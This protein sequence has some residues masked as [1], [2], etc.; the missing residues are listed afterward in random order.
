V[1]IGLLG[2]TGLLGRAFSR[3]ARSAGHHLDAPSRGQLDIVDAGAVD[4]WVRTSRSDVYVNCAAFTAV[5]L[6]EIDRSSAFAAN[7]EGPGNLARSVERSGSRMVHISTDFV[8]D[9]LKGEPYVESDLPSP[10]NTYGESKLGG[11]QRCLDACT[12]LRILR[13]GWLFSDSGGSFVRTVLLRALHGEDLAVVDDQVGGPT[14]ASQL[15]QCLLLFCETDF[16]D[17]H[18]VHIPS[19]PYV[20]WFEFAKCVVESAHRQNLIPNLPQVR[21]ITSD[22][23]GL[24]ARRPRDSRLASTRLQKMSECRPLDW[25]RN[26]ARVVAF[27]VSRDSFQEGV[28]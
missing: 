24:A 2:G 18:V 9:G 21:A 11:E 23:L 15:A 12:R 3:V 26:L 17:A 19:E 22:Q 10:I 5:D 28:S 13:A 6:A 20:S 4:R 1:K 27:L 16:D 7:A 14:D 25:R 8:F